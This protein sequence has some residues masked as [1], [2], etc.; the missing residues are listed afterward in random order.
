MARGT[1]SGF[2][3]G[4]ATALMFFPEAQVRVWLYTRPTDMRKSFDG[5]SALVKEKLSE[6]PL[7]G[8]LFVFVNRKMNYLKALYFDRSGYALWAKRLEQGQFH[9][10]R[11]MATGSGDKVALNMTQLK[12]ILEGIDVSSVRHYKRYQH[13][14]VNTPGV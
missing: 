3:A 12:L 11:G 5:L 10:R 4:I 2:G 1:R 7:S 8:Q 14:S 9:Y 6:D 13:R